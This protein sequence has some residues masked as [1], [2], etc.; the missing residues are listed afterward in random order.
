MKRRLL[1]I[2]LTLLSLQAASQKM[3]IITL[4]NSK[5]EVSIIS[6]SARQEFLQNFNGKKDYTLAKKWTARTYRLSDNRILIEFYDRQAALISNSTDFD[7]LKEVRFIKTYIDFLKKNISY[8]IEITYDKGKE[9]VKLLNPKKLEQFRNELLDFTSIEVYEL[10]TGQ[11]LFLNTT[12]NL[13]SA[14][15]YENIKALASECND[16]SNQYYGDME[17][18]SKKFI[19]GD[20]LLD[21]ET[22]GQLVYPKDEKQIIENHRLILTETKVYVEQ[23]YGNL[24][25]S[26]K[27]YYVLINEVNQKNGGGRKMRVLIARVYESLEEVREAQTKYE[28]RKNEDVKSEHFYQKIS[29]KYGKDFSSFTN[30][31]ID[32]LPLILNFD[33]EQLTF[34]SIGMAIVD[35]AIHW[36]HSNYALFDNWY[37]GVLAYYGQ[38]YMTEKK[39][40]NWVVK[41][42]KE[43]NVLIPHLVLLDGEDAFD[44]RGFYKDLSEWPISI[45]WAG[46]WDGHR[47]QM[48]KR[49]ESQNS[50]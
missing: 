25:K 44:M 11:L 7:K 26:E 1:Y 27:G 23:F 12:N 2:I 16:V 48:R 5:V 42:D 33:K 37:P 13:K 15:I 34:D 35:E 41:K 6:D 46:D 29:D 3:T 30:Q 18:S 43:F 9:I 21:Y 50:R 10:P 47:R 17:A 32:T 24:Y 40:G 14:A 45:K 39:E 38:C 22:D 49:I 20:P 8:K 19:N 4:D 36:N 31:L 28:K